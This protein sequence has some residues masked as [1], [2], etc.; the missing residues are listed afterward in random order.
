MVGLRV[1]NRS[2]RRL[3]RANGMG[4]IAASLIAVITVAGPL[5][6]SSRSSPQDQGEQATKSANDKPDP[7]SEK[8][9]PRVK[10]TDKP[11]QAEKVKKAAARKKKLA[12]ATA[13]SGEQTKGPL[14]ERLSV[15]SRTSVTSP[16][17]TSAELDRLISTFLT[18][19][20]AQGRH[21]S[22]LTTDV[23]YVRR[24][25][26]DL[27]GRPPT[28]MQVQSFL[29]DRSKD[30]RSRLIDAPLSNT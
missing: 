22:T 21:P 15:H 12:D 24:I 14:A 5:I 1:D 3:P 26:F 13:S 18:K 20:S 4:A 25:Y 28:P 16:T 9:K 7:T 8:D 2:F 6:Q 17:L 23:E 11:L 10:P 30:K 29:S 27:A 19:N